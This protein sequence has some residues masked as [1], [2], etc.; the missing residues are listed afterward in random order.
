M[1]SG[2]TNLLF[3]AFQ[4]P[5]TDDG[6]KEGVWFLFGSLQQWR[7]G[8]IKCREAWNKLFVGVWEGMWLWMHARGGSVL[9]DEKT[10]VMCISQRLC[11]R[12]ASKS[13][14][15]SDKFSC[16]YLNNAENQLVKHSNEKSSKRRADLTPERLGGDGVWRASWWVRRRRRPS[17][18]GGG[19]VARRRI[20]VP[21]RVK[22]WCQTL[23]KL[24]S[25][26]VSKTGTR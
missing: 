2:A 16:S 14:R 26:I 19:G 8:S 25:K 18:I 24:W 7:P 15:R 4:S 13:A 6:M 23:E 9:S 1:W 5:N 11:P 17:W 10:C 21:P 12:A 22:S 20:R 3:R